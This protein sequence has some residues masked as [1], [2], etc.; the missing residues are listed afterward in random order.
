MSQLTAAEIGIN[1][2]DFDSAVPVYN[3]VIQA[4][5]STTTLVVFAVAITV[6]VTSLYGVA[7]FFSDVRLTV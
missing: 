5:M 4:Y 2:R 6:C 3:I 7:A 1:Y